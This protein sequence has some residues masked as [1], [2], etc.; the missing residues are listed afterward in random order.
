MYTVAL[1]QL[2]MNMYDDND[3][4]DDN[5]DYQDCSEWS[6]TPD[7]LSASLIESSSEARRA[8]LPP[9]PPPPPTP[10]AAARPRSH[11]AGISAMLGRRWPV[12]DGTDRTFDCSV[13]AG[14]GSIATCVCVVG[15]F[16][17]SL[18]AKRI[19]FF[20]AIGFGQ[21][22]AKSKKSFFKLAGMSRQSFGAT[23]CSG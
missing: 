2:V 3:D 8:S 6:S 10:T 22:G 19:I 23:E 9:P 16:P 7:G 17:F 14:D 12:S 20:F 21:L 4:D 1:C 11:R 15:C 13:V 5:D 18:A